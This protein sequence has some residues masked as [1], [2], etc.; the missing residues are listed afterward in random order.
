MSLVEGFTDQNLNLVATICIF[1]WKRRNVLI[2][3]NKFESPNS[4]CTKAL[5]LIDE[6]QQANLAANSS[7]NHTISRSIENKEDGKSLTNWNASVD[8]HAIGIRGVV[9]NSER[10]VLASFNIPH[11]IVYSP[12]V[13]DAIVLIKTMQLCLEMRFIQVWFEGNCQTMVKAMISKANDSSELRTILYDVQFML[14]K[15]IGWAIGF[16]IRETNCVVHALAKRTLGD[17]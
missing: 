3:E 1:I 7:I 4:I 10:E 8:S 5:K 9:R 12:K 14:Q 15:N 6:F 2:F 17:E 13:V 16:D 11:T